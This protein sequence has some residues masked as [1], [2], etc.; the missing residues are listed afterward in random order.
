MTGAGPEDGGGG[1]ELR[2]REGIAVGVFVGSVLL[3][4]DFPAA[5]R[6]RFDVD[7]AVDAASDA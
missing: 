5:P 2:A 6:D 4:F 3:T 7:E 1:L